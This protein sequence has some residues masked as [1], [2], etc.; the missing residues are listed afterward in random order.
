MIIYKTTNLINGKFYIGQDSKNDPSYF[1]SGKLL[2]KAIEKYGIENFRKDILEQCI[3]KHE[4]NEREI[5]WIL[6]LK[7]VYNIAK[8]GSGGNTR[9]NFDLEA[10][11][12]WIQRKKLNAKGGVKK[13]YKW[14]RESPLKGKKRELGTPWMNGENNPAKRHDIREKIRQSKLG[15]PRPTSTCIY[16]GKVAQTTNIVR[17]HNNNCKYKI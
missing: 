1:G 3:S 4:L 14:N 12:N 10:Y 15:K 16:C 17:W 13:G 6:E 9:Y 11:N 2:H 5:Y 7:P 8:G